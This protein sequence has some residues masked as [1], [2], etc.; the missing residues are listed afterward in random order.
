MRKPS[1]LCPLD[2]LIHLL[3]S[4]LF[5]SVKTDDINTLYTKSSYKLVKFCLFALVLSFCEMP[6]FISLSNIVM[7]GK[8]LYQLQLRIKRNAVNRV[9]KKEEIVGLRTSF[10]EEI[11]NFQISLFNSAS[12]IWEFLNNGKDFSKLNAVHPVQQAEIQKTS[13]NTNSLITRRDN[14]N[15]FL[16]VNIVNG[17]IPKQS[18]LLVLSLFNF[19]WSEESTTAF[20]SK[21]LSCPKSQ[22]RI[23]ATCLIPNSSI[24][25]YFVSVLKDVFNNFEYQPIDKLASL[26]IEKLKKYSPLI[27]TF[28]RQIISQANYLFFD[29]LLPF[30][31]YFSLFGIC[32]N[33]ITL[34]YPNKKEELIAALKKFFMSKESFTFYRELLQAPPLCVIP[35]ELSIREIDPKYIPLTLLT[36]EIFDVKKPTF[37]PLSTSTYMSA[38]HSVPDRNFTGVV[39]NI[40]L[41][42]ELICLEKEKASPTECFADLVSM[43]SFLGDPELEQ[44]LEEIEKY[45]G[46]HPNLTIQNICDMVNSELDKEENSEE[47]NPILSVSKY[48]RQSVFIKKNIEINN[49]IPINAQSLLNFFKLKNDIEKETSLPKM[50]FTDLF[51]KYKDKADC[52]TSF[53]LRNMFSILLKKTNYLATKDFPEADKSFHDYLEKNKEKIVNQ[54]KQD[55]L[56]PYKKDPSLLKL[57]FDEFELAFQTKLPISRMEHIHN[58]YTILIGLLKEQGIT[59]IGADQIVPLAI[60]ATVYSNPIGLATTQKIFKEILQPLVNTASPLDSAQEYSLIQFLSSLQFLEEESSK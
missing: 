10:N 23:L 4:S 48:T 18:Y 35:K 3:S 29:L 22:Q 51:L 56:E 47:Q 19:C 55:F 9:R 46:Q 28:M 38:T 2:L 20:V 52:K 32:H 60:V 45:I 44:S 53:Q 5:P 17:R 26:C 25:V 58:S 49:N 50:N 27:P 36:P 1:S 6:I 21:L 14:L 12:Q 39:R 40:L 15:D 11:Q 16:N 24:Q 42:C 30:V 31:D 57:F 13:Q 37:V 7:S 33:E 8:L 43:T 59:D 41:D 54:I 34:F